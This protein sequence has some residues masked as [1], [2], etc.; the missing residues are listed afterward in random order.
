MA[1]RVI[2]IEEKIERQTAEV[3]KAKK[4]YDEELDKLNTLIEKKKEME[5]KELLE[6]F[7]KSSI[8]EYKAGCKEC[9][10]TA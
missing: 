9:Q 1:R 4:K 6:A 3:A 8:K 10:D 2:T 5:S 7:S